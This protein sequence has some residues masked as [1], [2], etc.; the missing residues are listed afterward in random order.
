MFHGYTS[1]HI[2]NILVH[3]FAGILAIV[4]GTTAIVSAKGNPANDMSHS[5]HQFRSDDM[6][7][8]IPR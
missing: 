2:T 6:Q 8:G 1:I 7:S 5:V 4:C 3:I